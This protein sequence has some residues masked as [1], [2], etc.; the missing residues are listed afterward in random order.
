MN[1]IAFAFDDV[2][3]TQTALMNYFTDTKEWEITDAIPFS[4][5]ALS[6]SL[7]TTALMC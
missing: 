6:Q 5:D 3:N 2:N 4:S 7:K 1:E